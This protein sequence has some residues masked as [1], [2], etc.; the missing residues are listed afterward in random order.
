VPREARGDAALI[1]TACDELVMG[2]DAVLGGEGAAAID[3][4]A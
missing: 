2:A 1:A 3:K 4:R